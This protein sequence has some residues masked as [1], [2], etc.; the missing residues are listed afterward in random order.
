MLAIYESSATSPIHQLPVPL[1]LCPQT[2]TDDRMASYLRSSCTQLLRA[3]T[4]KCHDSKAKCQFAQSTQPKQQYPTATLKTALMILQFQ[5]SQLY[6]GVLKHALFL[7]NVRD[8]CM[9]SR[10]YHRSYH[11]LLFV[12]PY[13][14]GLHLRTSILYFVQRRQRCEEGNIKYTMYYQGE[15]GVEGRLAKWQDGQKEM[16]Q[17]RHQRKEGA[18]EW[19]AL[20]YFLLRRTGAQGPFSS[21][22]KAREEHVLVQKPDLDKFC[23]LQLLLSLLYDDLEVMR[24]KKDSS[25][26][27][28]F[29]H[30]QFQIY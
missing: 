22:R 30:G 16:G 21:G 5:S 7:M 19:E 15:V 11:K 3:P 13:F 29:G 18:E 12:W 1:R 25:S 9:I 8:L 27:T 24:V 23:Q 4:C 6:T 10:G 26:G 20:S 17:S 2:T 14:Y 28:E